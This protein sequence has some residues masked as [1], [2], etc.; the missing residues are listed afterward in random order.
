VLP[1][2]PVVAV[3]MLAA[4]CGVAVWIIARV[5]FGRTSP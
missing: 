5:T 2:A 1:V 3:G 4:L